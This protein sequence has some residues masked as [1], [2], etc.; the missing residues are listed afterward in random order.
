MAPLRYFILFPHFVMLNFVAICKG[1]S[2]FPG[3]SGNGSRAHASAAAHAIGNHD[4][5]GGRDDSFYD[6]VET[7][8]SSRV[9]EG[10]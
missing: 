5:S 7:G 4:H 1:I 2:T 8:P 6:S 10:M 3:T 9:P